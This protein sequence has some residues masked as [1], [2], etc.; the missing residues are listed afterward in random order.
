MLC[1]AVTLAAYDLFAGLQSGQKLMPPAKASFAKRNA[2]IMRRHRRG[3]KQAAIA[4][5]FGVT[6]GRVREIIVRLTA[7]Q[8][9]R[10]VL[11]AR[12]GDQPDIAE[13]PDNTSIEVLGIFSVKLHG[14]S[15]RLSTLKYADPAI[16]TLGDLRDRSDVELKQIAN[17]GMK[18]VS[19]L[20]HYC[21]ARPR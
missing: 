20:R 17:V 19:A 15:A 3:E 21:P 10:A 6:R 8:N 5:H 7:R 4:R 9:L 11:I 18:L 14:W 16:V 1:P 2:E 13:L 12:Y